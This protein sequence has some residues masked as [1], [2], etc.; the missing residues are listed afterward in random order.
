MICLRETWILTI[1]DVIAWK[2]SRVMPLATE[3][4]SV[5]SMTWELLIQCD[6]FF[7]DEEEHLEDEPFLTVFI[8]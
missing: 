2:K 1:S 6:M 7:E 4:L 8:V 5:A 3:S